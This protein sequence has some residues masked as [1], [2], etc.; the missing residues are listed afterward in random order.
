M[1]IIEI[2]TMFVIACKYSNTHNYIIELVKSIRNFHPTEEIVVVDSDSE[3]KSYFEELKPYNVYIEDIQNKNWMIG[4]YWYAFKKYKRDFYYFLHDSMIVKGNMDYLK[5]RDLITLCYFNRGDENSSFNQYKNRINDETKYNYNVQGLGCYG[6]IFFC[7]HEVMEKLLNKGADKILPTNKAETGYCEG[8]YG[9]YFEAE[10]YNL[11]EC[12]LFGN[13]LE[14]ESPGG[15]SGSY[16]FNTSWQ[17]PI[18]KF[19]A[20]QRAQP[21]DG[22]SW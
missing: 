7:K 16:P 9:F 3:D 10:G 2:N 19:Y 4:A 11:Y 21:G 1:N 12:A 15:R 6:P 20:S 14:N 22:R 8:A 13:V 5:E 18:E 17:Y